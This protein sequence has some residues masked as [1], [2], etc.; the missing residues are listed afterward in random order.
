[1][2]PKARP[3]IHQLQKISAPQ[4]SPQNDWCFY[5]KRLSLWG[6][7]WGTA[8]GN[9]GFWDTGWGT[10]ILHGLLPWNSMSQ[11][12]A[13][14]M[15]LS[16]AMQRTYVQGRRDNDLLERLAPTYPTL[17]SNTNRNLAIRELYTQ[18]HQ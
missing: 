10:L 13:L 16:S 7:L 11:T 4:S 12:F 1:M 18:R 2:R 3:K 5:E 6:T 8:W 9:L 14:C 17:Q 15:Y